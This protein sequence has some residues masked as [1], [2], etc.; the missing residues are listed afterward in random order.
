MEATHY[1]YYY[2]VG[3]LGATSFVDVVARKI[4][5]VEIVGMVSEDRKP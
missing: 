1:Y 3:D 4:G 5:E 2:F